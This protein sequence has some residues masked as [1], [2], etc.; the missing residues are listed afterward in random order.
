[1]THS[2]Y[3]L[4]IISLLLGG[5]ILAAPTRAQSKEVTVD[6]E[7]VEKTIAQLT[8]RL[9]ESIDG[10][11]VRGDTQPDMKPTRPGSVGWSY[12]TPGGKTA[13]VAWALLESGVSPQDPRMEKILD[14]LC[15]AKI[16]GTYALSCRICALS[17]AGPKY[18]RQLRQ[19]VRQLYESIHHRAERAGV[20]NYY[21]PGRVYRPGPNT[22]A[23]GDNSVSQFALLALWM[24]DDAG[25]EIPK[26]VW[27]LLERYWV[28]GQTS[29]G[30]WSYGSPQSES[31][32]SMT[33]A[34]LASLY[35]VSDRLH[36]REFIQCGKN[37]EPPAF[38]KGLDW[39][40][41]HF[42]PDSVYRLPENKMCSIEYYLFACE[43]VGL[44][45]G[46]KYFGKHDWFKEGARVIADRRGGM[47]ADNIAF[48]TLFMLRG[49]R[50]M[51]F[52]KLRYDG[53][54]S[55]RPRDLASLSNWLGKNFE[56]EVNWQVVNLDTPVDELHDA[57]V[58]YITGHE[59]IKLTDPQ[60][61][62]LRE[63]V[64]QG[65]M[66][67]SIAECKTQGKPF[68]ES[69][70]AIYA[71]M[72]PQYELV[73]LEPE[74]PLFS[75]HFQPRGTYDMYGL[76]NGVRLLALHTTEDLPMSYQIQNVST[77]R[78]D[79]EMG[80][81]VYIYATGKTSITRHFGGW[82]PEKPSKTPDPKMRLAVLKH[83]GNFYPEP[84]ALQRLSR[85]MANDG[86][87]TI[88]V[89]EPIDIAKLDNSYK[90][91]YITGTAPMTLSGAD[92]A[93]LKAFVEGGGTLLVEAA[94][95]HNEIT[96]DFEK[97]AQSIFGKVPTKLPVDHRIY[98]MPKHAISGVRY[99][100][101]TGRK[102]EAAPMLYGLDID[103]R[104]AVI[105][106]DQDLQTGLVGSRQAEI[107]G[108]VPE[109]AYRL[110]Q[111]IM[112]YIAKPS[113]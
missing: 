12:Y 79:Y 7:F 17:V 106:S 75:I 87:A 85:Q 29:D 101:A 71:K 22:E 66:I 6:H 73:K 1:M 64:L 112:L 39:M 41:K 26:K 45:S 23:P 72:F 28:E 110:M 86:L 49:R 102:G 59:E 92:K 99:R 46:M 81:N 61:D 105:L 25:V 89:S 16:Y 82:W 13:M 55:N 51:L 113:S 93:A 36:A 90:V 56:A 30:G 48:A 37:P 40:G 67:F 109:D 69:M 43:R 76:S 98:T 10:D 11:H 58:L 3:T 9:W 80:A 60:I 83:P 68:D 24:A 111:N 107:K 65:G 15:E 78:N 32:A 38:K 96:R 19:D 4:V 18:D 34:G 53:A 54:W 2:R 31:Y 88:D 91:A 95:G 77:R 21:A 63:Y 33:A 70:R 47:G 103:G 52:N 35:V 8:E 27:D 104:T 5:S 44:A 20:F 100:L 57:P 108:Y 50:P 74:H 42:A 84:L 14:W 97:Q 94:G 62:K